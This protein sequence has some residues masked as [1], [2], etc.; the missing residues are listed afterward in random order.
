MADKS[1][2]HIDE[3]VAKCVHL[4]IREEE[5]CTT[6]F[7]GLHH[8]RFTEDTNWNKQK[9][10]FHQSKTFTGISDIVRCLKTFRIISDE[11]PVLLLILAML[12]IFWFSADAFR[13]FFFKY[14]LYEQMRFSDVGCQ[15]RHRSSFFGGKY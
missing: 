5:E 7:W 8:S 2:N 3:C 6:S 1:L 4:S 13:V 11:I 9:W 12:M 15:R 14:Y 10:C